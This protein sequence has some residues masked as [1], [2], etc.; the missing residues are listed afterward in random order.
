M[1][2]GH[3]I[4]PINLGFP[5][6]YDMMPLYLKF[7]WY[8]KIE[9][10]SL[11]FEMTTKWLQRMLRTKAI[12]NTMSTEVDCLK[13]CLGLTDLIC[14]GVGCSVGAGVYSLIGVGAAVAGP[15]I[16]LSFLFSGLA[17]IFT[18]LT[19]SEFAA[20]IP[21]TGSAY[22]FVYVSF[23]EFAAWLVGWNLTLG[24]GISAGI[25]SHLLFVS[26][27]LLNL[28]AG[29]ARSWASYAYAALGHLG[30]APPPALA[31]FE[32]LGQSCSILA[33]VL[34]L[35]CTIVLLR[36]A[37]VCCCRHTDIKVLIFGSGIV[38]IQCG[39]YGSERLRVAGCS[40]RWVFRSR[41]IELDAVLSTCRYITGRKDDLK[42]TMRLG[43]FR[44]C[45]RCWCHLL[46]LSWI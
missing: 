25:L 4:L 1:V 46:C 11:K 6:R 22:T 17:C 39:N 28:I 21:V 43:G 36:G 16:S 38:Q 18:S 9:F 14:Y 12:G 23:G 35:L 37:K 20:R 19:Y 15:A 5:S 41:P 27:Y 24:Y 2:I 44:H 31:H 8:R 30:L 33:P 13:K 26:M 29:V 45:V 10:K 7:V 42:L 34:V 32:W 40:R 3:I